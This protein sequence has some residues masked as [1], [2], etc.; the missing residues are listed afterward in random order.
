MTTKRIVVARTRCR[1]KSVC[2]FDTV[3]AT[4]NFF[5]S[6]VHSGAKR[7]YHLKIIRRDVFTVFSIV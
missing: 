7:L 5:H 4:A 6:V 2:L 1:I 3:V